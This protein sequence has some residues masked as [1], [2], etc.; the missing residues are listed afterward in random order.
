MRR[1]GIE[2]LSAAVVSLVAACQDHEPAVTGGLSLPQ[3]ESST[4]DDESPTGDADTSAGSSSSSDGPDDTDTPA[5]GL[6]VVVTPEPPRSGSTAQ[7][8]ATLNGSPVEVTWT[9]ESGPAGAVLGDD[10]SFVVPET[11]GSWQVEATLVSDPQQSATG[12]VVAD[13]RGGLPVAGWGN[14]AD[15]TWLYPDSFGTE[16]PGDLLVGGGRVFGAIIR[17]DLGKYTV[18]VGLAEA[19]GTPQQGFGTAGRIEFMVEGEGKLSTGWLG[20]SNDTLWLAGQVNVDGTLASAS[21]ISGE[22]Y[23]SFGYYQP[24]SRVTHPTPDPSYKYVYIGTGTLETAGVERLASAG[25]LDSGWADAGALT[26]KIPGSWLDVWNP[27]DEA[28]TVRDLDVDPDGRLYV[29]LESRDKSNDGVV[30]ALTR[31]TAEGAPDAS[32]GLAGATVWAA[33]DSAGTSPSA[34]RIAKD[35]A[36]HVVGD[37]YGRWFGTRLS[38]DGQIDL[39]YGDEGSVYHEYK[40]GIGMAAETSGIDVE[41]LPGGHTV[42]LVYFPGFEK[43][44]LVRFDTDGTV[45]PDFGD[46]AADGDG[47]SLLATEPRA[48]G[49][50]SAGRVFVMGQD[51]SLRDGRNVRISAVHSY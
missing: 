7:L 9:L 44:G 42:Y 34:M 21:P 35:G 45:N 18:L 32:F 46:A 4:G 2:L 28:L 27:A 19:T 17:N 16:W 22:A 40:R 51:Y 36:I 3:A 38:A 49:H 5:D 24:G 26:P 14:S 47:W 11:A 29:L 12:A 31:Y 50:G 8:S 13:F 15:G 30:A 41:V 20:L 43:C 1:Q 39:D 33:D 48:L 6:V 10:G 25:G 23:Q 37:H